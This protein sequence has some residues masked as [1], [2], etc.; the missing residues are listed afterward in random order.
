MKNCVCKIYLKEGV[1]GTGFFCKISYNNY[2]IPVMITNNHIIDSKFFKSNAIIKITLNDDKEDKTISINDKRLIYTNEKYDI[3]IIEI[4]PVKDNIFNYMELDEKIY[5][6][7][8]QIFYSK[9]SVYIIHYANG[10]KVLVS[11]GIIN[12]IKD[13]NISHLCCTEKGSSGSP[14]LNITNNKVIGVHK[15]ASSI[16]NF[17]L[18]TFLKYPINDFFKKYT[19][20]NTNSPLKTDYIKIPILNDLEG[21]NFIIT[22]IEKK[23]SISNIKML[24]QATKH[25]DT[26]EDFKK[27]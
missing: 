10:D 4:N 18:G 8:S 25:G 12:H 15:Q 26:S 22:S 13:Y 14:I 27:H 11:Y 5:K 19:N 20:D 6:E 9:E 3:T 2:N 24:Y 7:Q 1:K 16:S 17:N 23:M 21:I